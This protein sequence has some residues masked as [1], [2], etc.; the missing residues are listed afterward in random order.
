MT[1]TVKASFTSWGSSDHSSSFSLFVASQVGWKLNRQVVVG[2]VVWQCHHASTSWE[3]KRS[4]LYPSL[5][6]CIPWVV[7][8]S[9][10]S[11]P[12]AGYVGDME[13]HCPCVPQL[14]Q[15]EHRFRMLLTE[16]WVSPFIMTTVMKDAMALV[17]HPQAI[18][19]PQ[20]HADYCI[21]W[22]SGVYKGSSS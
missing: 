9:S 21:I 15:S 2:I 3:G 14:P 8:V 20:V 22:M 19:G 6:L 12:I 1:R 7:G 13:G 18:W 4:L 11:V 5:Q 16:P 10:L 17:I